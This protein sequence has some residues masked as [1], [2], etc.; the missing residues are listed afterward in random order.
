MRR[1]T[2]Y[3]MTHE[4]FTTIQSLA[5]F[6]GTRPIPSSFLAGTL[7]MSTRHLRRLLRNPLR[8]PRV[9]WNRLDDTIKTSIADLKREHPTYNCQWLSE[10]ASD[11][12]SRPIS[13]SSVWRILRKADLLNDTPPDRTPR[14]RFEAAATGDL[15][16][17]DTTWGYWLNGERLC[18]ILLLDDY[19]RYILAAEFFWE[20]SAYNNMWMIRDV[21][22]DYGCFRLLYTDN[23]SFFKPIRHNQSAYQIHQQE[24][25]ESAI[26]RACRA[27]GITH[28]THRPYQPQGKGKIE[29]LFRFIQERVV[30]QFTDGM[31]LENAQIRLTD[32]VDWYNAKH[33]NR[34]IG[35]VPKK[36]FDPR[37]F[38]PL[39]GEVDLE[40]V[41]CFKDTRKVDRCN[42]FSYEGMTYT[43]PREQ[44]LAGAR[45]AL[46]IHPHRRIR[47]WHNDTFICELPIPITV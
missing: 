9:P 46:H 47:V 39:S 1:R 31:T 42:T 32:W 41:F 27:I 38:T 19:S 14:T 11:R 15:V 26:T 24:E 6:P 36:R 13:R 18:L 37:G 2:F 7:G 34:T 30:S 20:D 4:Q 8:R 40:D 5:T 23:A 10:L 28:I 29:R 44:C 21:V 35:C 25:Y 12:W 43:I 3:P 22:H 16:Q 17:M 33:I 45:V